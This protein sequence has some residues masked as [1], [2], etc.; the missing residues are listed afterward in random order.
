MAAFSTMA[1]LGLAGAAGMFGGRKLAPKPTAPAPTTP[2]TTTGTAGAPAPPPT[3]NQST[4]ENVA[5]AMQ[6]TMRKRRARPAATTGRYS[7]PGQSLITP[8]GGIRT[9]LGS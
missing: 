4:S 3:A 7:T 9:L 1:L 5:K 8:M 6:Q 2:A